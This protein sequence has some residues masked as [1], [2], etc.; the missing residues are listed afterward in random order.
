MPS[1]TMVQ[2]K[3]K[4]T[5]SQCVLVQQDMSSAR[6]HSK[7]LYCNHCHHLDGVPYSNCTLIIFLLFFLFMLL[8]TS[9]NQAFGSMLHALAVTLREIIKGYEICLW[10]CGCYMVIQTP[11]LSYL[12]RLIIIHYRMLNIFTKTRRFINESKG[13][14]SFGARLS[15]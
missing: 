13:V 5:F 2:Q 7:L 6:Q 8:S 10:F 15:T 1:L 9:M 11:L 12:H 4:E 3:R 14:L